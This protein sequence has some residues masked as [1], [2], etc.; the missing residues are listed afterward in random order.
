MGNP[1]NQILPIVIWNN[2]VSGGRTLR[3]ITA[4]LFFFFPHKDDRFDHVGAIFNGF[5]SVDN[6]IISATDLSKT[7]LVRDFNFA[8]SNSRSLASTEVT[9]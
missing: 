7:G 8:Y 9:F 1:I 2:L 4:I 3:L 5:I 6:Y